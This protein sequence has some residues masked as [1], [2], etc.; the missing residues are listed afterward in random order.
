MLAVSRLLASSSGGGAV[1]LFFVL[2]YIA[3]IVLYIA[4]LWK[5]FEKAGQKGWFAIIP[6]LNLYVLIKIAGREGWWIILFLIPCVNIVVA[7]LVYIDVA[8]KF[9]KT[10]AYGIGM[11]LL[12]FIFI[13]MLGFGDA[14]YSGDRTP[15][16]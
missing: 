13:P 16:L 7:A 8:Q 3:V 11:W 2:L 4:G 9:G 12:G 5:V 15:V 1:V 14:E 6:I 10:A